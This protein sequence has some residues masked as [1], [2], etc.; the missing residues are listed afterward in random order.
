MN[1]LLTIAALHDTYD[2]DKF[3]NRYAIGNGNGMLLC[4]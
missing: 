3:V 1:D 2:K 4:L